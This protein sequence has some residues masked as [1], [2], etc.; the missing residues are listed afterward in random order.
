MM[1]CCQSWASLTPCS[2]INFFKLLLLLFYWLKIIIIMMLPKEPCEVMLRVMMRPHEYFKVFKVRLPPLCNLLFVHYL[3][4][5]FQSINSFFYSIFFSL[6][7][8]FSSLLGN[9]LSVFCVFESTISLFKLGYGNRF[10][11]QNAE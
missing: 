2:K 11:S 7:Y 6:I 8:L 10:I 3:S 5:F 1:G 4:S 9:F